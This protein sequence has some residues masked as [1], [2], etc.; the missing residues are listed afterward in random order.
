MSALLS[1]AGEQHVR[2]PTAAENGSHSHLER[3]RGVRDGKAECDA[4]RDTSEFGRLHTKGGVST[5]TDALRET[6]SR[7][8]LDPPL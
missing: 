7:I 8:T 2:V 4:R 6:I 3:L 5:G 1:V